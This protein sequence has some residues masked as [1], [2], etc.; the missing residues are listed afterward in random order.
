MDNVGQIAHQNAR[1]WQGL[2]REL[3][4]RLRI[5]DPWATVPPGGG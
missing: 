4:E 1:M 2:A 3:E 5:N